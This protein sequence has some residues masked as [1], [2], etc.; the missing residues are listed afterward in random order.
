MPQPGQYDQ[1]HTG[2]SGAE[3]AAAAAVADPVGCCLP[4]SQ[5]GSSSGAVITLVPAAAGAAAAAQDSHSVIM[6]TGV[7][8]RGLV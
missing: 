7:F 5:A 6:V 4:F 2:A 8:V 1:T 3:C